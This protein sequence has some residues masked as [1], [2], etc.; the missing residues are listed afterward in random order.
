G[1]GDVRWKVV[2]DYG[3]ISK[4]FETGLNI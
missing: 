1:G 4:T 3:G 2:T